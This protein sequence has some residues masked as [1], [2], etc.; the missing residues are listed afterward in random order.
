MHV[1]FGALTS[2]CILPCSVA[3]STVDLQHRGP[4][5]S[6]KW[7]TAFMTHTLSLE[8][9]AYWC[10][11]AVTVGANALPLRLGRHLCQS[12]HQAPVLPEVAMLFVC[13]ISFRYGRC[14]MW[15][16]RMF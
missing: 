9:V 1:P 15:T 5:G 10:L 16:C 4:C 11:Y 8:R 6:A 3:C 2:C 14:P 12:G 7:A 13:F